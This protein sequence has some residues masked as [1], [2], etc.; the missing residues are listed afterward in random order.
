[1][2][3]PF[4]TISALL[5]V[6]VAAIHAYRAYAGLPVSIGSHD[7]PVMWSW[8]GAVVTAVLGIG[9]FMESRR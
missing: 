1:M 8:I 4:S 6:I 5:L 3:K 9:L 2:S 7:I